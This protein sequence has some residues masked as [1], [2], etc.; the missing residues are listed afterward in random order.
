[1]AFARLLKSPAFPAA[2]AL[3]TF[4]GVWAAFFPGG[5]SYEFCHYGDIGRHIA[6]GQGYRTQILYP[7]DAAL[8]R[9]QG[10]TLLPNAPVAS[11]FPLYSLLTG[12]AV[13]IAGERD[14]AVL[15]LQAL[16]AAACAAA[17]CWVLLTFFGGEFAAP[18]AL[19]FI[20]SPSILRGFAFWGYPDLLFCLLLLLFNRAWLKRENPYLLGLLAGLCWLARPNFLLWVPVYAWLALRARPFDRGARRRWLKIAA[21]GAAAA[22][23]YCVYQLAHG[24]SVFNPNFIWNLAYDTL[25]PQPGWHYYRVFSWSEFGLEHIPLILAKGGRGILDFLKSLPGLWQLGVLLPLS[26]CGFY[27]AFRDRKNPGAEW[28]RLQLYLL[29]A[30]AAVFSFLR[31][32]SLGQHVSGRYYL[33]FAPA[34]TASACWAVVELVKDVKLRRRLLLTGAA[35]LL[36]WFARF[37]TL[38]EAGFGHPQGHPSNWSEIQ[39][40]RKLPLRG[41]YLATNIP[42]L[43]GWYA[44]VPSVLVP[45]TLPGFRR[46]EADLKVKWL[47]LSAARVGQLVSFP[48][49]R[50]IMRSP[51]SLREFCGR[52]GYRVAEVFPMGVLLEKI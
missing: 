5:L 33:W 24:G 11:R 32:E 52:A 30:Q 47:Y 25:L 3:L 41:G 1:M 29:V 23:P 19:L 4:L 39:A 10:G 20:L 18:A 35:A 26:G 8:V 21:G 34:Y 9:S 15:A 40:L 28:L 46:L 48:L 31:Y 14:A 2:A 7:A 36:V 43:A 22:V 37:Y 13:M 17:A 16:L 49:W 12:A 50:D 6:R 27:L 44:D 51:A 45:A 42:A 38:P